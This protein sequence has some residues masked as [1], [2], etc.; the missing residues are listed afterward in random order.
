MNP[1]NYDFVVGIDFGHGET[2]AAIC[3]LCW[4]KTES[5][6][7]PVKDIV[8]EGSQKKI[9]SAIQIRE[10]GCAVIGNKALKS[11]DQKAKVH[12]CFKKKPINEK[13]EQE[14]IMIRFMQEVYKV[15]RESMVGTLTDTNHLVYIAT[16][17]GWDIEAQKIYVRMAR[18][19]GIPI[20]DNG[21]TKE[22]RAAFI[23]AQ[24]DA[25]SGIGKNM[26][27]GAIVFDMGSSTL[28]FTYMKSGHSSMND[29]GYD[30]GAS[31][32]ERIIFEQN[33]EDYDSVQLFAQKYPSLV[34]IL[35]F[36]ARQIKEKVYEDPEDKAKMRIEFEDIVKDEEL[37][38]E[39]YKIVFNPGELNHLLEERGY[40]REIESAMIDFQKKRIPGQPIYGVLLTGGASRMDFIKPLVSNC[41]RVPEELIQR[42]LDPSLTISQGVAEVAR[43]DLRTG[44]MES[45]LQKD[46]EALKDSNTIMPTFIRKYGDFLADKILDKV[47]ECIYNFRDVSHTMS[48]RELQESVQQSVS[49][50]ITNNLD[51]VQKCLKDSIDE[52]QPQVVDKL[53][54]IIS[55][56]SSQD[57]ELSI[58]KIGDISYPQ[59]PQINLQ[60]LFDELAEILV[61][62]DYY[63]SKSNAKSGKLKKEL[64]GWAFNEICDRWEDYSLQISN[65]IEKSIAE[66]SNIRRMVSQAIDSLFEQYKQTLKKARILID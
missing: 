37:E 14:G 31:K 5:Q 16:P 21:V 35:L 29:N 59:T 66:D 52:I 41:W 38:D 61:D 12:V 15:I 22:S 3:S 51:A 55:H 42:D 40:I 23:R 58:V 4:N 20:L 2:S 25:T 33:Q 13:G 43:M 57:V 17:S 9:P 65:G 54:D 1:Q 34:D 56:Y 28:D 30:C 48:L 62:H 11:A 24:H 39:S 46:F 47:E 6:L 19:A 26:S 50:V 45:S 27:K 60:D 53:K 10:N 8:L 44:T 36:K 18:A 7:E 32:V 63:A 64:R 49:N